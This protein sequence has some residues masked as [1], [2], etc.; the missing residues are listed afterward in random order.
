MTAFMNAYVRRVDRLNHGIGRVAMYLIFAMIGVLLW[1]SV[2][3]TFFHPSLWTLE[4]AQF[5]MVAYYIL[6]G[7][8]TLQLGSHVRMDLLYGDWTLQRKAFV[9][10]FT[11]FFLLI[12]LG[13]LIWGGVN[14]LIYS[15]NFGERSPSPWRP[16]MWPIKLVMVVG[17]CLMLA[18]AVAE[19]FRD[20]LV[21]RKGEPA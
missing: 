6:G 10:A 11:V 5:I 18:Q 9:D 19:L 15:I 13:V 16:Y 2:S 12:F 1:S 14:S 7:P 21:L 17:F 4:M 3:K 20:I 8:Y